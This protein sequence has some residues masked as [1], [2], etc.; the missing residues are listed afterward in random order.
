MEKESIRTIPDSTVIYSSSIYAHVRGRL[1]ITLNYDNFS[2]GRGKITRWLTSLLDWKREHNTH[3]LETLVFFLIGMLET[4]V[5]YTSQCI[6]TQVAITPKV[7]IEH[8]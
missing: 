8:R 6:S 3:M 1:R 5:G 2:F 7:I 4:L